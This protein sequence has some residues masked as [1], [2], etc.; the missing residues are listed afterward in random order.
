MS[1]FLSSG[2]VNATAIPDSGVSRWTF[3]T[4]DT[5]GSTAVDVWGDNDGTINGATTDVLG[6]NQ[7]YSTNE[8][9]DFDG[10]NDNVTPSAI[11]EPG[12]TT[13][14]SI[15]AWINMDTTPTTNDI[16]T[17][18]NNRDTSAG[19]NAYALNVNDNDADGNTV[20]RFSI[21][22]TFVPVDGST[23][24][25]TG[26]WYHLCGVYDGSSVVIYVDGSADGSASSSQTLETPDS[27][28]IAQ[29]SAGSVRHFDGR[30]DDVRVYNKGLSSSE[31]SDLY[32][33][34]AI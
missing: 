21:G 32:N 22:P 29:G 6:A 10:S 7:T 16:H 33:N 1:G 17:V 24:L 28:R 15:S 14:V 4:A 18:V 20:A 34:G 26:T 11:T 30:V 9:F 2:I 5:S 3:D 13:S 8:A 25:N 31:V 19:N 12:G 27:S 23:T